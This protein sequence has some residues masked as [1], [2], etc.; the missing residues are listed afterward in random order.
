MY[1][2][3]NKSDFISFIQDILHILRIHHIQIHQETI[4]DGNVLELKQVLPHVH[5]L[6]VDLV[7]L[8]TM[9]N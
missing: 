8:H 1:G 2:L 7:H 3:D 9:L 4:V 5:L 6:I